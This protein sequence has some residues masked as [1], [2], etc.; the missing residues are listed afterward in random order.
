MGCPLVGEQRRWGSVSLLCQGET[1]RPQGQRQNH[2]QAESEA[3]PF[4]LLETAIDFFTT[5]HFLIG[6]ASE[7]L[8]G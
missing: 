8:P 5:G 6:Q 1:N 7:M 4:V 2:D 3:Q